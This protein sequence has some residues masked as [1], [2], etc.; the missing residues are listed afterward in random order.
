MVIAAPIQ[1]SVWFCGLL[2]EQERRAGM[3]QWS[4]L[5]DTAAPG[6]LQL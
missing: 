3:E 6:C 4:L 2:A 1:H 5:L